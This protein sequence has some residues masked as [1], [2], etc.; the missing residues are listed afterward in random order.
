M[1]QKAK[2]ENWPEEKQKQLLEDIAKFKQLFPRGTLELGE[3]LIFTTI[4]D[5][6]FVEAKV[7]E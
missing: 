1:H 5:V 3:E 6:L 4:N 2:K 7:G